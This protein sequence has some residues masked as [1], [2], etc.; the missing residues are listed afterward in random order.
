MPSAEPPWLD[1]AYSSPYYDESHKS[2]QKEMRRY[3]DTMVKGEARER[4]LTDERPSAEVY[5][6]MGSAEWEILAMRMG[7]GKHLYVPETHARV[8]VC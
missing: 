8:A 6:S 3:F 1:T 4:E 7:P 5:E 2:L